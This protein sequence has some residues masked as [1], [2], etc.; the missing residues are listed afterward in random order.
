MS[1]AYV[2]SSALPKRVFKEPES[3]AFGSW[4]PEHRSQGGHWV[5]SALAGVEVARTC[6]RRGAGEDRRAR[7]MSGMFLYSVD[8]QVLTRARIVGD[9]HLRSLDAIHL[10]TALIIGVDVMVTYDDR[11]AEASRAAGLD[12]LAPGTTLT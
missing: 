8:D 1:L 10:A 9:P 6:L 3:G 7:A 11:L 12:V 5:C 2:D 4:L